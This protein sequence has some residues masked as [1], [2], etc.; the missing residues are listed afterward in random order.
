[1]SEQEHCRGIR[2]RYPIITAQK[3]L[4][5]IAR[6][7]VEHYS[8]SWETGKAMLVCIDKVTC[9][10]MYDLTSHYWTARMQKLEKQL[11]SV[12]DEQD[13]IYRRRQIEWMKNTRMAVVVSEEQGEVEKFRKWGL[14][15]TS[16]HRLMKEG[17][18]TPEGP[19]DH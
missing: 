6:D 4:N 18:E 12:T 19:R 2:G 11:S 17:F 14:D 15:T 1:M 8:T 16:H 7:F 5:R 10:R 13:E 9:A 3:R